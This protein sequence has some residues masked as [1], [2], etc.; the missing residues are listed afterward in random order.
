MVYIEEKEEYGLP[1]N[2]GS[3]MIFKKMFKPKI[4][5]H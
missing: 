5:G 4:K 3:D 2:T 1:C